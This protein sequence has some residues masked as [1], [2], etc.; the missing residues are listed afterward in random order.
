[1]NHVVADRD[2]AIIMGDWARD[3]LVIVTPRGNG[4]CSKDNQAKLRAE[5]WGSKHFERWETGQIGVDS[6]PYRREDA[7]ESGGLLSTPDHLPCKKCN[8][9]FQIDS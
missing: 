2:K 3:L 8:P 4:H 1:M 5:L 7:S 6:L 9:P